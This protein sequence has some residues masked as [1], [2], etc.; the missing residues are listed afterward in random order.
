MALEARAITVK[1][2]SGRTLLNTVTCRAETGHLVV[3]AGPVGAGKSTLLHA[4]AGLVQPAE[5]EVRC[6]G[7]PL[8]HGR[9]PDTRV[10]LRIGVVF[11]SPEQQLFARDVAAEFG[12]SL[13][14]YRLSAA[15]SA[16]RT[17]AA[18]A[19]VGL[20][21][22]FLSRAPLSLSGGQRRRVA[23]ATSFAPDPDWLL[24][25]EPTAGM[26]PAAVQRFLDTLKSLHEARRSRG[27]GGLIIATHDLEAFL[28]LAD[29]VWVVTEG[30]LTA[31]VHPARLWTDPRPL[32]DAGLAPPP[33]FALRRTLASCGVHLPAGPL[34]AE[35]AAAAIARQW[36]GMRTQTT[37][38]GP[39]SPATSSPTNHPAA[40]AGAASSEE[41]P[42]T[43]AGERW[44]HSAQ[45]APER[46]QTVRPRVRHADGAGSAG[47]LNG[48]D[49]RAKWAGYAL[50]TAGVMGQSR[51]AGL[52]AATGIAA[53]LSAVANVPLR[54]LWQWMRPIL[55]LTLFSA[56]LSGI[57]FGQAGP[58]GLG[59]DPAGAA[60]T[61]AALYRVVLMV[62]LSGLLSWTTTALELRQALEQV[63]GR[64]PGM[65]RPAAVLS[66]AAS[67]ILRFIPVI[68]D[69][70]DRF[71]RI[72][73][74]R[75]K[76]PAPPG[77]IRPRD[78]PAVTV[79]LLAALFQIAEDLSLAM[80]ARGYS[81]LQPLAPAERCTVRWSRRD[82]AAVAIALAITAGLVLIR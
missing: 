47:V 72:A 9:R 65:R 79:P 30:R 69:Q 58:L 38:T 24:F 75:A 35:E 54:T 81:H 66:L 71:S 13:R 55:G 59:F 63:I 40:P 62:W 26:D 10:L 37:P 33:G 22:N 4:L 5:G 36:P 45:P 28:P 14:P 80:E 32:L 46:L 29:R 2:A 3:I 82:W 18:L 70:L 42:V 27:R 15:E 8:W 34:S 6:D 43:A 11:Q 64:L 16:Q 60:R 17:R 51:P 53:L 78:L 73:R 41:P 44:N 7:E 67:L 56:A 68:G 12:Y 31:D 21:D 74:A 77:R 23:V 19:R 49:A 25:D 48:L 61:L 57:R 76:S 1:A 39:E 20:S 50:L 52:A